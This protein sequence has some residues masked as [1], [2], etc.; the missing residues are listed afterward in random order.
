VSID[1]PWLHF[2]AYGV[3]LPKTGTTSLSA[4]MGNYRSGHEAWLDLLAVPAVQRERGEIDDA[5]F[6]TVAKRRFAPVRGEM[7]C[8]TCHHLYA[9]I[10]SEQYPGA[11]FVVTYR[12]VR[13]WVNSLLGLTTSLRRAPLTGSDPHV[14][15]QR[16]YG[17]WIGEG[18]IPFDPECAVDDVAALP[19][20]MR[21]WA[22]YMRRMPTVLPPERTIWIKTSDIAARAAELADFLQIPV[23]SLVLEEAHSNRTDVTLDRFALA[24][25]ARVDEVYGEHCA[26]LMAE[27]FPA[28]HAQ[29]ATR[30]QAD[31]GPAWR[32]YI[33]RLD[34]VLA[35]QQ[36]HRVESA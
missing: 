22:A 28:E 9:D 21:S 25:R 13:S 33:E 15:W 31:A 32:D 1:S 3:G 16:S 29:F 36:R 30:P 17:E 23:G 10:L 6:W 8:V 11:R 4:M 7:D 34:P 20:L 14:E 12:D 19:A 24:D 18:T 5:E 35:A 2:H 27:H 26:S